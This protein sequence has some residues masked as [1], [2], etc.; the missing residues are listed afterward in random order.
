MGP[1][2]LNRMDAAKGAA[3]ALLSE[4]YK[5][6]DKISLIVFHV[7]KAE[8]LVPPTKSSALTKS[9]LEAMPCGGG[10]PLSHA[11]VMAVRVGMNECKIKK[12]VGRVVIILISDGRVNIP[13]CIS[14]GENFDP[15]LMPSVDG[16]PTKKFLQDEALAV[17]RK[18]G[19]L[20]IDLIVIDTEDKF[21]STGIARDIAIASLGKYYCIDPR[22][23]AAIRDVTRTV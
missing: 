21:V 18:I 19:K 13:L 9:R 10:S 8:I 1:Q 20:G 14:E 5:A 16:R 15:N 23:I 3:I 12:D 7:D 11:L 4:A 6:R 22:N 17:A 2:A